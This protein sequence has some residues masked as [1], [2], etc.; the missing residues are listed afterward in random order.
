MAKRPVF[1]VSLDEKIYKKEEIEFEF[2]TGFSD[3]QKKKSIDSLHEAYIKTTGNT[4][5]LEISTKSRDELGNKLS[6]FNLTF[7]TKN[8]KVISVES[9]FQ[10]SKVFEKGG[11]YLDLLDVTSREAKKDKRLKNSGNII[12]FSLYG[13]TYPNNPK[14]YFYNWL[15]INTLN[16]HKEL[17][18]DILKYD[19]FTDIEFNPNKSI[20]CQAESV[21]IYVSL[22]KQ[23]L[24]DK[25]LKNK[26]NFLKIVYPNEKIED[27]NSNEKENI[28]ID[29]WGEIN[30][31][32]NK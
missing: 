7:E 24:L 21:A 12:G 10:A 27:L 6:A 8:K 15:Y 28:Q 18:E 11:P 3:K 20:N 26:E 30:I 9:A 13:K 23:G 29:F 17:R 19:A 31:D 4:K 1:V 2:F 32:N 22:I 25:A 5:I 14:T 16:L